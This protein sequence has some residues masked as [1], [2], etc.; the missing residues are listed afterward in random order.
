MFVIAR[1]ARRRP[2]LQHQV[3]DADAAR[4]SCG[5]DISAWSRAYQT[6]AIPQIICIKCDQKRRRD[7]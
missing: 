7:R 4:T 1:T 3:S 5:L 6:S 2:T